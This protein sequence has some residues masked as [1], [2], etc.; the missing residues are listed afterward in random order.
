ML[1]W[2][3]GYMC[4]FQLWLKQ[5][6]L[7]WLSFIA[8]RHISLLLFPLPEL[9]IS[10]SLLHPALSTHQPLRETVLE[11]SDQFSPLFYFLLITT[12][13]SCSV[14]SVCP[15]LWDPIDY[16]PPGSSVHWILQARVLE[17]VAMPSSGDLPDPGIKPVSL[18]S[19]V[20][21]GGFFTTSTTWKVL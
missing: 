11:P 17:W 9:L 5:N 2:T 13:C 1:Q 20:L 7:Q 18:M 8:V 3:L 12:M 19:P 16:S 6:I 4:L 15:T 14:T 10:K 21:S